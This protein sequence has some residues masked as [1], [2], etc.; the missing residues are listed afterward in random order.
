MRSSPQHI[1]ETILRLLSDWSP[2]PHWQVAE[3]L[4]LRPK[5]AYLRLRLLWDAKVLHIAHWERGKGRGAPTPHYAIGQ[6]PDAP[7]LRRLTT[8]EIQRKY[9]KT[10]HGRQVHKMHEAISNAKQLERR[11]KDPAYAEEIR[12][13]QREW[14]RRKHGNGARDLRSPRL[15]D[16]IAMQFGITQRFAGRQQERKVA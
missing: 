6:C 5:T 12:R 7:P 14:T 13:Y 4:G 10:E 2:M 1:Q 9:R 16:E 15:L 3:N 8:A 11:R